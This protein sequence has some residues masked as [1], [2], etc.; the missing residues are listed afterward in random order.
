[1]D[2]TTRELLKK[3]T[4]LIAVAA[5]LQAVAAFV[6]W[7]SQAP[8]DQWTQVASFVISAVTGAT[9]G[10]NMKDGS[11]VRVAFEVSWRISAGWFLIWA[12]MEYLLAG[13]D[14]F[15]TVVLVVE[16]FLGHAFV[17]AGALVIAHALRSSGPISRNDVLQLIA[18]LVAV[19]GFIVALSQGGDD[20]QPNAPPNE[21]TVTIDE[22]E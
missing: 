14:S 12:L 5:I 16:T 21:N 7:G 10:I 6:W 9:M 11:R 2:A 4:A 1:M 13:Q 22:T 17:I 18:A 20:E 15:R 3:H 8:I 19:A